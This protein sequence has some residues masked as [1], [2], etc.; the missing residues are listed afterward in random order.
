MN[1]IG[2]IKKFVEDEC[3]KPTAKYDFEIIECHF[4]PV[5]KYSL[6]LAEKL[7]ADK[8]ILEISA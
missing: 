2:K 7:N 1:V 8:E 3:K 5:V 4:V 6:M